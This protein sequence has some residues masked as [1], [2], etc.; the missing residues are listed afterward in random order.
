MGID[1]ALWRLFVAVAD[2][3]SLSRAAARVGSD[4]P[5][6][7]RSVR[8]L[9]RLVGAPLFVRGPSGTSVT[10]LGRTLLPRARELI[11]SADAFQADVLAA[12]RAST[13]AARVG[14]VDFYPFTAALAAA[15][16]ALRTGTRPVRLEIVDLPWL[17]HAQAVL[18]RTVDVGFTL[19]VERRLPSADLL[20]SAVVRPEH[21][22]YV[23]LSRDHPLGRRPAVPAEALAGEPLHLP[24]RDQNPSLHAYALALLASTGLPRPVVRASSSFAAAIQRVAS[25]EGWA[26]VASGV[27]TCPPPGTTARPLAGVRLRDVHLEAVWHRDADQDLVR[28]IVEQVGSQLEQLGSAGEDPTGATPRRPTASAGRA[29]RRS[30]TS[31]GGG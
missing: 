31:D 2:T 18:A 12:A 24:D 23:L 27:G 11:R 26:L 10:P 8:R 22:A 7:S 1:L 9:E 17:G 16:N 3:G 4:Q 29:D 5:A 25:G 6:V 14:S 13:R 19:T 30:R 15:T 28:E 20:R 21:T